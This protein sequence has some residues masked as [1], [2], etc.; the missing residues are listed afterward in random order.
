MLRTPLFKMRCHCH[1]YAGGHI[2]NCNWTRTHKHLVLKRTL[3]HL[4]KPFNQEG[5]M[6]AFSVTGK[7]SNHQ[8]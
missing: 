5:K 1:C 8:N 4:A 3:N 2:S 7:L 6:F